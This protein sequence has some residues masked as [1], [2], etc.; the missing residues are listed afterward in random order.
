MEQNIQ[1]ILNQSGLNWKVRQEPIQTASGIILTDYR[2]LVREDT[3]DVLS[4]RTDS[5]HPY[6]N[7]QLIELLDRV[8]N[9]TG[10]EISRGGS[11]KNGARVYIQLKSND[12]KLG[13][14]KIEGYLTGINSFDGSTSLAF[15]PSNI[16]ISCQNTFFASFRQL[17]AKVRH[18]SGMQIKIDDICYRLENSLDEEKKMFNNIVELSETRF[19][20]IIKDRVIRKLFDIKP[21]VNLRDVEAL[22]S[23]KFNQ[24]RKFYV[25]LNGEIA[26]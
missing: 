21:E 3:N 19:D 11:F 23:R 22:S 12:L 2:A 9:R 10:L 5:Y 26:Q 1:D 15:G 14:D 7:E 25:D 16:T 24:L 4:V 17:D 8:S 20:D 18:T 13:N 6:Q